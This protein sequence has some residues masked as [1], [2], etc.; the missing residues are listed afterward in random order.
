[1]PGHDPRKRSVPGLPRV[2]LERARDLGHEVGPDVDCRGR[3][4]SSRERI[5]DR[6]VDEGGLVCAPV[7]SLEGL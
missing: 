7:G 5:L 6:L 4:A 2:A 1:M 3:I